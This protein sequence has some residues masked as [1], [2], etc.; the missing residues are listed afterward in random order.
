MNRI[1][2]L[3]SHMSGVTGIEMNETA[4]AQFVKI[5]DLDIYLFIANDNNEKNI[6]V[7]DKS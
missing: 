1:D 3:K 5:V 6:V 4:A 2:A 7:I